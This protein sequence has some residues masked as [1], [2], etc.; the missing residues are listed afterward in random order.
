MQCK[1]GHADLA[2][3]ND[4]TCC[5]NIIYVCLCAEYAI[6]PSPERLSE[7]KRQLRRWH[8]AKTC[9][10]G[11][12][13]DD[14]IGIGIGMGIGIGVGIGIGIDKDAIMLMPSMQ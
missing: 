4:V 8:M 1:R 13:D 7:H 10:V 9:L 14:D 12:D 2:H 3:F 6:F 11:D 5:V